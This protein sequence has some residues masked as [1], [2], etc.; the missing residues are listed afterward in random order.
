MAPAP[1]SASRRP[2]A[3]RKPRFS[4]TRLSLYLFCPLA[5]HYYYN[6]KLRWGAINAGQAFG[7]SLH[8]ALEEFHRAGGVEAA[9]VE[10]LLERFRDRWSGLGY[11]SVEEEQAHLDMGAQLLQE[12]YENAAAAPREALLTEAQVKWDYPEF[13]LFG[14]IDR[15][16]RHP[17]GVLEIVDYKSGWRSIT[18]EEV[19]QNLALAVYQLIIARLNPGARVRAGIY[20]LRTGAAAAIERSPAELDEV[21]QGIRETAL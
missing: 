13:V 14:K 18:E 20:C 21:E 4:P 11:D 6:R 1:N 17:D 3:P 19:R 16:D 5:Y 7:G 8:R 10:D 12:Y 2:S 15:L 9:S